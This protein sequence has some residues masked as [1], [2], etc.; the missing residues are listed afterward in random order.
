MLTCSFGLE[1]MKAFV[2]LFAVTHL[3]G[4]P[5]SK[6]A[7]LNVLIKLNEFKALKNNRR[8]IQT[9]S[10]TIIGIANLKY[11]LPDVFF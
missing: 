1:S 6:K 4:F 7:I 5:N 10:Q 8:P 2:I 3:K 9:Q 11:V